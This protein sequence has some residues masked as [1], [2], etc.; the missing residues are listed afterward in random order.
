MK[1]A[2]SNARRQEP[3]V[4]KVPVGRAVSPPIRHLDAM[5]GSEAFA[6]S[7][8]SGSV[9]GQRD[10]VTILLRSRCPL[11]HRPAQLH[12]TAAPHRPGRGGGRCP[13]SVPPLARPRSAFHQNVRRHTGV[14][15]G[16]RAGP[17]LV[18]LAS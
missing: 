4:G 13:Y 3:N 8:Y 9:L 17:L 14:S 18:S 6:A 7:H 12:V 1:S 5:T 15:D 2:P 11:L 10:P 16:F